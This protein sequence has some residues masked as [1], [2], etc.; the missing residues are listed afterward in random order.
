MCV[1]VLS[2]DFIYILIQTANADR[3]IFPLS[4]VMLFRCMSA[5]VFWLGFFL[6][7]ASMCHVT[8]WT[9]RPSQSRLSIHVSLRGLCS[10]H[11]RARCDDRNKRFPE[12]DSVRPATTEPAQTRRPPTLHSSLPSSRVSKSLHH[13]SQDVPIIITCPAYPLE[14]LL[15]LLNPLTSLLRLIGETGQVVDKCP[16]SFKTTVCSKI[17]LKGHSG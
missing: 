11:H 10:W 16:D 6:P 8:G 3:F 13:H 9:S 2:C 7:S 1:C 4:V 15:L 12:D 14:I 17:S 5:L